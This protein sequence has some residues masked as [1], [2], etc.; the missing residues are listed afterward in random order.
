MH[1]RRDEMSA[2]GYPANDR[3]STA[4]T[5]RLQR[6]VNDEIARVAAPF[7]P[8]IGRRFEFVCECGRVRCKDVVAMTLADYAKST[9]GSVV[10]H[11]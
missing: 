11:D 2:T 10:G 3:G 5:I 7:D 6:T 4:A 8:E 9:P 1:R